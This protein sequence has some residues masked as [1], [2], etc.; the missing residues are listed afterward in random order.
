MSA[1][2]KALCTASFAV[3]KKAFPAPVLEEAL[4]FQSVA[5]RFAALK[6]PYPSFQ[7]AGRDCQNL[8]LT[9]RLL[10]SEV[11]NLQNLFLKAGGYARFGVK[12]D[13]SISFDQ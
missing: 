6:P 3:A 5:Q 10:R 13:S 7:Q 9:Q 2:L 11:S 4:E 1:R 8:Y 12:R